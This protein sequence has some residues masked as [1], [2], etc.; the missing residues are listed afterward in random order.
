[1][2]NKLKAWGT[3]VSYDGVTLGR[4]TSFNGARSRAT[5]DVFCCD[6]ADEAVERLTS[7]LDEGT[8]TMGFVLDSGH[9]SNYDT[10][11]D[12]YLAGLTKTLL[13][14]PPQPAGEQRP[15]LSVQAIITGLTV[16]QFGSAR[17]VFTFE[18]TFQA[19]GKATY[20]DSSGVSVTSS[21]STSPSASVSAT[22]S[23][24][25]SASASA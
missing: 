16:P 6:S 10:L 13:I 23:A 14:Q 20:T 9:A 5:I 11:N 2:A 3:A 4:L 1:M 21:P 24:S 7:G 17:D 8:W 12:K 15:S 22:P 25:P 19:T 18:A